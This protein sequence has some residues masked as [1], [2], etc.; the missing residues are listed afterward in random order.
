MRRASPSLV[1]ACLTM[2]VIG[3]ASAPAAADPPS[4]T[5]PLL[6]TKAS[7]GTVSLTATKRWQPRGGE[8]TFVIETPA[9]IP[10]DALITVCFGWRHAGQP[11][12][13]KGL[14]ESRPTRIVKFEPD[15]K[16]ITIAATVPNLPP[17]PP[18]FSAGDSRTSGRDGALGDYQGMLTVPVAD[19]RILV[20]QPSGAVV[21]DLVT[22]VGVTRVGWALAG[23]LAAVVV[24]LALLA[25]CS[26]IRQPQLAGATPLL[27]IIATERNYASLSQAQILLWTLVVGASAVYVMALSGDLIEISSGTLVLLGISG[28]ATVGAKWKGAV[29]DRQRLAATTAA[30]AGVPAPGPVAPPPAPVVAPGPVVPVPAGPAVAVAPPPIPPKPLPQWADLVIS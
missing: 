5:S 10:G 14:T 29:D 17:A 20:Y 13:T 8:F 19:V 15:K 22:T 23:A 21:V 16:V 25:W 26:R 18:L 11:T 12:D 2:I 1:S 30:A 4:C 28:V 9:A 27:R 24:G 3:A 6:N 7:G